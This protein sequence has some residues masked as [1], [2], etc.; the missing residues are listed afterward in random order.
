ML[1]DNNGVRVFKPE[2][3]PPHRSDA[4]TDRAQAVQRCPLSKHLQ[5]GQSCLKR[6]Q[7]SEEEGGEGAG[8]RETFRICLSYG[9]DGHFPAD[10]SH[11]LFLSHC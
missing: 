1:A 5:E 10:E 3:S 6:A 11:H 7:I 9:A 2:V 8:G 4:Q